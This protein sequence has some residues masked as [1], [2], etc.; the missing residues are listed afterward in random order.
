MIA[1]TRMKI[2]AVHAGGIGDLLLALPALRAFREAFPGASLELMG[3]PERLSLIAHDLDADS[4]HSI[5]QSGMAYFYAQGGSLPSRFVDFFSSFSTTLILG[6]SQA[7]TLSENLKRTGLKRVI[8]LPSFPPEREKVHV[9][10]YLLKSLRGFGI[11]GRGL[12]RPLRLP[13]EAASFAEGF[14]KK[15]GRKNERLI[16]AIHP[17][18]GSRAKNWRARNFAAVAD[19]VSERAE[20]LLISGPAQDS[21]EEVRQ[22]LK[23]ARPMIAE[24]LPLLH[25]AAMLKNSSAYLGNDS[26]ITHLSAHLGIPTFAVFGPT[27]PAVWAPRGANVQIICG[28]ESC[29][30]CPPEE[31]NTCEGQCLEKITS[32]MVT[33]RLDAF[34]K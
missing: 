34:L 3:L 8:L 31:R 23:K 33:G 9:S 11:E 30:P 25:L 20:V 27:D 32:E 19:W 17:G 26:G 6:Q 13:S 29:S 28:Q 2:L 7:Q 10:D 4:I 1:E 24:N 5:D 18:S 21:I 14:L 12:S 22:G 15:I 16:L